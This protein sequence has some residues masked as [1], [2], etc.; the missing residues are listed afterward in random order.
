MKVAIVDPSLFTLPYDLHLCSSIAETGVELS[1][2][3]RPL[4]G[5]ESIDDSKFKFVPHFY[6]LSEKLRGSRYQFLRKLFLISKGV[7]HI[8]DMLFFLRSASKNQYDVIHFQWTPIP[9]IDSL[10]IRLLKK[11][12]KLIL[13]VHDTNAFHGSAPSKLQFRGWNKLLQTFNQLI[14]H[15]DYSRKALK[16]TLPKSSSV[17]AIPHGVLSINNSHSSKSKYLYENDLANKKVFVLFGE[18]KPYKGIETILR[19]IK[20]LDDNVLEK[21]VFVIAGSPKMDVSQ[22]VSLAEN[23][24][25]SEYVRF[26][27]RF[28][29]DNELDALLEISDCI[30]FPY[31]EIDASGAL[32]LALN[33]TKPIIASNVGGFSDLLDDK[34]NAILINPGEH[35]QLSDAIT[36]LLTNDDLRSQIVNNISELVNSTLSWDNIA[37]ETINFYQAT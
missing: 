2:F 24:N 30:L 23:L 31:T 7:E 37:R 13:T 5:N 11:K 9:L 4:R 26:D 34:K 14:V 8:F 1:F 36:L 19:A 29:P 28:V 32:M 3:G 17:K 22:L 35:K 27:F 16:N 6:S 12:T 10:F 25:I 33:Y 20:H 18:L 15:T 21:I